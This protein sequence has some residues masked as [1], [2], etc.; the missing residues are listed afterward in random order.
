EVIPRLAQGVWIHLHDIFHPF[1]YPDA[2]IREG[3]AWHEIYLLRA[4][5]TCN[6][7]FVVRWFQD[8]LWTCHREAFAKLP[9]V[10]RN[11]GGNVWLQRVVGGAARGSARDPAVPGEELVAGDEAEPPGG[12][13]VC[14]HDEVVGRAG[15]PEG[16]E[17]VGHVEL[18]GP[19]APGVVPGPDRG[20]Q[21]LG[22][23]QV[24]G[25]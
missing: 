6:T 3:R 9:W 14:H 23:Q 8:F 5:L 25:E 21:L 24:D 2:W 1:E 10:E 13:V 19:H 12:G 7:A 4:F 11:A 20:G 22:A 15:R 17:Q 18:R 16:A